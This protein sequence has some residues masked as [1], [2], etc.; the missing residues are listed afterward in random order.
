MVRFENVDFWYEPGHPVLTGVSL[1][2]RK[3]D[4]IALLGPN[5]SGKST[6]VKHT[7]GLNRPCRG[8]V[9]VE[10]RDTRSA[11]TAQLAHTVG[12]V[13]QSPSHMLFAPTVREELGFGPRNLGVAPQDIA[14]RTTRAL[15]LLGL[16][17]YLERAPLSLSFGQQKRVGI[18]AVLAMGSRILVLDEPTAGQDYR[19]YTAFMD[20]V[21]GL[22]AFDAVLF[23]THDLDLAI[24]YAN[25]VLLLNDGQ[26]AGDGTPENVLVN[27][28]LLR[29]CNVLPTTLLQLN[30]ELLPT[31]GRLL[32]VRELAA[33]LGAERAAINGV[34]TQ[35]EGGHDGS[36]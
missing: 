19:S 6:L 34:V 27:L 28:A 12:F 21:T 26:I 17:A 22:G 29:R 7:L 24:S 30:L 14:E 36:E 3:G 18:G 9:L 13:F 2:I 8:R 10:G 25:R 35:T 20:E 15:S 5:G 4:V 1:D 33:F 31:T 16:E 23:V 11:T 32:G